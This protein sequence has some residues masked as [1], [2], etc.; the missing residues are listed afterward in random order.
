M[1]LD[2]EEL[3]GGGGRSARRRMWLDQYAFASSAAALLAS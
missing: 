3:G 2:N 1:S